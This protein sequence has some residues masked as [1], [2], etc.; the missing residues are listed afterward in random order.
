MKDQITELVK[1]GLNHLVDENLISPDALPGIRLERARD[2]QH[3]DFACNIAM[4]LARQV[5][6]APRDLAGLIVAN[7]PDSPIID[8]IEIAGPGFINFFL[9]ASAQSNVIGDILGK[10][11]HYGH[12]GKGKGKRILIEFVS[13]N[14][15]GPLHVGHGRGA[16]YGATVANLLQTQGYSVD[17][18]YYVNDAGRQ[19]DILAASVYI[20]YLQE[21]GVS[22]DMPE[23][24]YQ[25]DYIVAIA[26]ELADKHADTLVRPLQ[27]GAGDADPEQALDAL[28]A[29]IKSGLADDFD[30]LHTLA[31]N[32]ILDSIKLDLQE[33]G[34]EYTRWYSEQSLSDADRIHAVIGQLEER[35][36]IYEDGGARWFR[37]EQLGDE[38]DR[39]V[40][41]DNGQPTYFASDIAYHEDKYQRGYDLIIDIWGADHHGYIARVRAALQ[42][43]GHDPESL[44]VLLV[45][46]VSLYRGREKMQMS[47][48]SGQFITLEQLRNEVGRDATRFFYVMRKCEQHLDFDLELAKSSTRDNPVYYI[49]Y[50]HARISRLLEK[51]AEEYPD[52]DPQQTTEYSDQLDAPKEVLLTGKLS[53]YADVLERAADNHEPHLLV[54]YLKE[55]AN[56]FHTYYDTHRVLD[57]PEPVKMARMG[58]CLAVKQVI[59]NGLS[60][61]GVSAPEKM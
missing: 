33:F 26:A 35:G 27:A 18:E 47:T 28:I 42:A 9:H 17:R 4:L 38:K 2:K 50:A 3:G 54:Y 41:R 6:K 51:L 39:V 34:V 11:E 36:Y 53:E 16:A 58:L 59:N 25:G 21:C 48:R 7:I 23:K 1:S 30:V 15:T 60:V 10:G 14:P 52:F 32:T 8:R 20:R 12:T 29:Q 56:E 55:L 31:L 37:S 19:M 5:G 43:L 44:H 13:A 24:T 61:L 49:Q 40:I 22:V 46:F 57:R 45:Q